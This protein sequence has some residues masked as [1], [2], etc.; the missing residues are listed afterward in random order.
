M[1]DLAARF[2]SRKFLLAFASGVFGVLAA[3]GVVPADA[4]VRDTAIAAPLLFIVVEGAADLLERHTL[5][6]ATLA[7][8]QAEAAKLLA[9]NDPATATTPAPAALTP[10]S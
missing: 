2:T 4:I 7:D 9:P 3:A 10:G 5:S 1:N 6:A 8:A